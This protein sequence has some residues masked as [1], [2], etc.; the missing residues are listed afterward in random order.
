MIK[1]ENYFVILLLNSQA[2]SG[3]EI[4]HITI[5]IKHKIQAKLTFI[6]YKHNI[7]AIFVNHFAGDE[8]EVK[9]ADPGL[10]F[11]GVSFFNR[12]SSSFC[13]RIIA[14]WSSPLSL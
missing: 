3:L 2:P 5:N 4:T 8:K 14:A 6:P 12:S 11:T 10:R 13:F 7:S 9:V 1:Y